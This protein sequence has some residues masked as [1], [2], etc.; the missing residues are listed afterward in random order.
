M[1]WTVLATAL[2]LG[3]Y[4]VLGGMVSQARGKYGVP[5]PT[6]TGDPGFERVY[7]IHQNTGEQ[8]IVFLP[9]LWMF[10]FHVSDL[11]AT[12]LA[13]VF[14]AGR[15][16]YA[17]SYFTDPASR[18]PGFMIGAGAT[19]ILLVGAVIGAFL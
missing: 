1:Q 11:W 16:I 2:V 8:L 7:R 9:S 12:A 10:A 3:M 15:I 14:I 19:V 13:V 4:F 6:T 17:R 18:A 5:A